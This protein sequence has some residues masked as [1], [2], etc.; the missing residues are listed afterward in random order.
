MKKEKADSTTTANR[1]MSCE[2]ENHG[3]LNIKLNMNINHCN[4]NRTQH[5]CQKCHKLSGKSQGSK[6]HLQ[7]P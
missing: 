2:G 6:I 7:D 3:R 1:V 5:T 4:Y